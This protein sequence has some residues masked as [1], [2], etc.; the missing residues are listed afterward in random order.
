MNKVLIALFALCFFVHAHEESFDSN[1]RELQTCYTLRDGTSCV[2]SWECENQCCAA[3]RCTSSSS[4]SGCNAERYCPTRKTTTTDHL[5]SLF[6]LCCLCPSCI[7][8]IITLVCCFGGGGEG[9]RRLYKRRK[10]V[11]VKTKELS[12]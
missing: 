7:I 10:V 1:M 4:N 11:V 8:L 6:V 5:Y 9:G 2:Y 3:S 12:D